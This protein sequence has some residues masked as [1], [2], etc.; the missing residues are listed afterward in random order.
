MSDGRS[1]PRQTPNV[2]S[3][4]SALTIGQ[5]GFLLISIPLAAQLLF[6]IALLVISRNAVDAHGWE[7][8]SQ[9]VLTR[10]Y[11]LK[12]S[13]LM[14]Q[15]NLRAFVLTEKP[16]FLLLCERAEREVPAETTALSELVSDNPGQTRLV[17]QMTAD[18]T[19]F[20]KFEDQCAQLVETGRAA[21][22]RELIGQQTGTMLMNRFLIPMNA[23][24]SEEERLATVRHSQASRSNRIAQIVVVVGLVL[25]LTLAG[26]L[27]AI[28]TTGIKRR[29]RALGENAQRVAKG[30][31][32]LPQLRPGDEIAEVDRAFREMATGLQEA[33]EE[34]K[35]SEEN[36][37]RFFTVSL[38]LLCIAG[39]DGY[40]KRLNPVWETTLG[41][42]HSQLYAHPFIDFVHPDDRETTIAEA[43]RLAEGLVTIR[44]ENRY[45]CADGSYKW[46]LWSAASL[47]ESQLI[48]AAATDITERKQY[49]AA[50][51]DQN[52]ALEAVNRELESFS[53]SVSHD[54]RAPLRAVDS[55]ARILEEDSGPQL[56]G[57][58]KRLLSII[59]SEARRMGVLIDDLLTFGRLSRQP[60]NATTIDMRELSEDVMREVRASRPDREFK[61]VCGPLPPARGD[62]STIRQVLLNLLSNAA[63]YAKPSGAIRIEMQGE[64]DSDHITYAV[65]DY[66]IG[67]D[68]KYA[69][70][71][72]GVFQ[73]LHSDRDYEGTGVGLAIVQ[74]IVSRHG[75]RV[76]GQG[77]P[78]RG[79]IFQ[80]TLPIKETQ[81]GVR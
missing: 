32:L 35:R 30:E 79:A 71:I 38:E 25:N 54:L 76:W 18:A 43:Q 36:L 8:H 20:L 46:L 40:F 6:G 74:R 31:P 1:G 62:R 51:Q 41:Y 52:A 53:Y 63:K 27:A 68:M 10:A 55:Y 13:L 66:G 28:F 16:E 34:W 69:E 22:A 19:N 59:R 70:K 67:F 37:N 60:L 23:F 65:R 5:K 4:R 44:F 48:F 17:K 58:G 57:E 42:S 73:R 45:R 15:S 14:A 9:Q 64:R 47:P 72:F 56:D 26:V 29:L 11:E 7:L 2:S 50:L 3:A 75:G 24:L 78:G 77:E 33:D 80:F 61:F 81:P 49:E 12:S 21:E 39:F